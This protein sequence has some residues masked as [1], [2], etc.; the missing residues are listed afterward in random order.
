V[1]YSLN[2]GFPHDFISQIISFRK[3]TPPKNRQLIVYY[4][5]QAADSVSEGF[6]AT[7]TPAFDLVAGGGAA[8]EALNGAN[9]Y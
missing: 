6:L 1:P 5:P 9:R 4:K 3:S 7:F 2:T 8:E